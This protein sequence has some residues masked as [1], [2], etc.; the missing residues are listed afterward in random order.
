M[1][2]IPLNKEP[3]FLEWFQD[4]ALKSLKKISDGVWDYSD[5]LL[6]YPPGT[7]EHYESIQQGEDSYSKLITKPEREY[8]E[9]IADKV[10]AELPD[11]F[12]FIDLGPGTAHKEDFIFA[13]AKR[14]NKKFIYR[15]VDVSEY[16]L[17]LAAEHASIQDI[18]SDPVH[19]SFEELP[20]KLGK[21]NTPRFVSLGLTFSNYGPQEILKLLKEIAGAGG[22]VFIDAHMRDRV[23]MTELQKIYAKDM[24]G[25][26][27]PKMKLLGLDPEK[28]ITARHTDDG[29]RIWYTLRNSTPQL[30]AMGIKAGDKLLVF[31]SLR[32]TRESFEKELAVASASYKLLDSDSPFIGAMLKL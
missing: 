2:N 18:P 12:E 22:A 3:Y 24:P 4:K 7:G 20:E 23:D 30:E 25:I 14:A 15:P 32:Y 10:V 19:A 29:I 21:P 9:S 6:L 28:D 27:D 17:R 8:L 1:E 5:S 16:F 13:A 26:I 11:E 31:R